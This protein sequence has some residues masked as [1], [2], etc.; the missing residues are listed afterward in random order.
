MIAKIIFIVVT[1]ILAG[2]G[3]Y[4]LFGDKLIIPQTNMKILIPSFSPDNMI[5]S[6]FTC[7]GSNTNPEIIIQD[8]PKSAKSLALIMDDPDAT[9]GTFVHWIMWNISPDIQKIKSASVPNGAVQGL[10]GA[11]KTGYTGPCP[12]SGTHRY[13]FKLYALGARLELDSNTD[14]AGLVK[15]MEGNIL[16]ESQTVG[17]Y[18]RIN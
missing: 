6:Q 7:D 9:R 8:V 17:L 18:K 5:P 1:I 13:F 12:P 15:A 14:V 10:N 16:A 11:K 3:V 2:V 4:Y